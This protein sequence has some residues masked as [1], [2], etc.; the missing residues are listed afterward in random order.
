MPKK[1]TI[2]VNGQDMEAVEI[3]FSIKREDWNEYELLDGG[4]VRFKANVFRI[5]RVLD[6]DGKP[7]KTPDGDP[8]L[9]VQSQNAVVTSE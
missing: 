7:A 3:G 6:A 5:L 9:I 8:F 1:V 4:I 2:N